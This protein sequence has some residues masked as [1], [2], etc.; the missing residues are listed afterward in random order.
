MHAVFTI[1]MLR[2]HASHAFVAP[3]ILMGLVNLPNTMRANQE[4]HV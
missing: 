2:M 3:V 4:D 1:F